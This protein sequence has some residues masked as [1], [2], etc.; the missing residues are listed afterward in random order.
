M[1]VGKNVLRFLL[2][3]GI[4]LL[5]II[6][7]QVVTF[8]FSLLIPG[9]ENFPQTY[10]VLFVFL[11][12]ITYSIGVFLAGWLA[13]GRHWLPGAPDYLRRLVGALVGAYVPL[14]LALIFYHPLEPGNPFFFIA[15]ITCVLGFYLP[16]WILK[17]AV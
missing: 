8:V 1:D 15:I 5:Q 12:G 17:P 9:M 14:L 6:M 11:L 10:P 4:G 3:L 2:W 16:G 13:L 7:T